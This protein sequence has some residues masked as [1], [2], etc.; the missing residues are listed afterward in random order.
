MPGGSTWRGRS[1][2]RRRR[3][4]VADDE[5]AGDDRRRRRATHGDVI[6]ARKDAPASYHL[7]VTLDDAAQG[8]THV[9]RGRDLFA[10]THVHRLLQALLGLPT[11]LYRHHALSW[12]RQ[13]ER[14][15]KRDGA[16]TL[17]AT[18]RRRAW[19]ARHLRR[20]SARRTPAHWLSA[21]GGLDW[22]HEHLPLILLIA[23]M[24]A[25]VVVLVRG[26]AIFL[27][28]ASNEVQR[29]RRGAERVGAQIEQDD[30]IPHPV[31][32]DRDHDRGRDPVH[33]PA[34][35]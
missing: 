23:A 15:A 14:L 4:V 8:I 31:P 17:A 34:S 25:T 30:A 35:N 27:L 1:Q 20:C 19:T 29:E 2:L 24:I 3:C 22:R 21:R 6:L 26:L 18:A 32:G 16:P 10:A 9:V 7:A 5:L 13:G 33:S 12:T 11:P 28:N